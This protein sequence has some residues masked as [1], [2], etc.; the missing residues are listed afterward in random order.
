MKKIEVMRNSGYAIG[1]NEEAFRSKLETLQRQ[2]NQP[3]QFKGR[4]NELSALVRIEVIC[5]FSFNS[6]ES[7]ISTS[8]KS[9]SIR[10]GYT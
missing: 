1:G 8:Y 6:N 4:L 2:L 5:S 3:N 10:R 9:R 7:E